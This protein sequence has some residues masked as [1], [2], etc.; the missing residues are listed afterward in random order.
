MSRPDRQPKAGAPVLVFITSCSCLDLTWQ[1][2][3]EV[4]PLCGAGRGQGEAVA[5][6]GGAAS[7]VAV[8]VSSL[9]SP[10]LGGQNKRQT[11]GF[12][13]RGVWVLDSSSA[14]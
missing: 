13:G 3:Q 4:G 10:R 14:P 6:A 8:A 11:P 12:S 7:L 9:Q 1:A 5:A 2:T